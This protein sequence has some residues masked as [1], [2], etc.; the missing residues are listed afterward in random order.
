MKAEAAGSEFSRA[1]IESYRERA[2]AARR[3]AREVTDELA[4][5]GLIDRAAEFERRAEWLE[6][7]A[8]AS[9]FGR[10]SSA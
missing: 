8:A 5:Q 4:R 10:N 2:E 7:Q 9:R 3:L 6:A 1:Q